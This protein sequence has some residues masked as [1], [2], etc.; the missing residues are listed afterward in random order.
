MKKTF[1]LLGILVSWLLCSCSLDSF[2]YN[3]K[4]LDHYELSTAVIPE[5]DRTMYTFQS[6][7]HTLY[8]FDVMPVDSNNTGCTVLYCHGNK[9]SIEE[10]W[11][12]VEYFYQMG[13]RCFIFD[14][15]GFGMSQGSPSASALYSDGRAA[16][17]FIVNTLHVDTT[18]LFF[19]GYS[20]GNVVSIDLAAASTHTYPVCLIAESPFASADALFHTATPLDLPGSFVVDDHCDNAARVRAI[21]TRFLLLHGEAD[22]FVPWLTNGRIVFE[23]APEPKNLI[24]IPGANHE[25]VPQTMGIAAYRDSIRTFVLP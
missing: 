17:D 18:R 22:D 3:Q 16:L 1:W 4:K 6:Q 12:R 2:L 9:N 10:Y 8:G 20:L 15:Q 14:Y 23:N 7:G 21:H 11:Y 5:A 24:L 25:N 19:Y 13:F